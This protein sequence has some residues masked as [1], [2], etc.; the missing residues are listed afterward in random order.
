MAQACQT[1]NPTPYTRRRGAGERGT[2]A[3]DRA[4]WAYEAQQRTGR[5]SGHWL[6]CCSIAGGLTCQRTR[7]ETTR[8]IQANRTSG[9]LVIDARTTFPRGQ[10]AARISRCTLWVQSRGGAEREDILVIDACSHFLPSTPTAIDCGC[11]DFLPSTDS[12][13]PTSQ[14]CSLNLSGEVAPVFA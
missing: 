8:R 11:L 4:L 2:Q 14:G 3:S 1:L 7:G 10:R 6:V 5:H 13:T 9:Y 12:P